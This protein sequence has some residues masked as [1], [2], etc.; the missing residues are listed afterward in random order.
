MTLRCASP[1]CREV[2]FATLHLG[3]RTHTLMDLYAR[4]QISVGTTTI[5]DKVYG[6]IRYRD[7]MC[8]P[9]KGTT[10]YPVAGWTNGLEE[11]KLSNLEKSK[12]NS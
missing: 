8:T 3:R 12:P 6:L 1:P 9:N 2:S 7:T 10:L 4:D 11:N 5:K